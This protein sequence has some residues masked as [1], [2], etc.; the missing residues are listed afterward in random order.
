VLALPQRGNQ[1]ATEL[2]ARRLAGDYPDVE[3]AG[4]SAFRRRS[5]A[6]FSGR[7]RVPNTR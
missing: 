1:R 2:I 4:A 6:G 5:G 7:Y 3:H